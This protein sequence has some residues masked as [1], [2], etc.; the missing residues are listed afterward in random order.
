VSTLGN[1]TKSV[2]EKPIHSLTDLMIAKSPGVTILPGT[3]LGGAPSVR[4]RG[5]SSVSLSNAP[6]WYVD[7]VRF[8]ANTLSSG[9]D[10][11]FSLLSTLNPEE[12]EDIEIVKGPSAATLYGTNA[13]N[14]VVLITTK[15]GKAGSTRWTWS[16]EQR[17][18]VDRVPYQ[19]M[20]A[21]W[22]HDPANASRR[23][24]CQLSSMVT[25]AFSV[26]QGADCVSDSLTSYNYMTDKENTF[27]H[28]GK[29][30]LYGVNISGG[31]DAVRFFVSGDVDN[32]I[33][34]IEMPAYEIRRFD[35]LHVSVP[36]HWRHPS[37]QQRSAFRG[38]LSAALSPKFDLGF[39]AGFTKQDRPHSAGE[40]SDHRALLRRHAELRL[41]G[42]SRVAS[43][44]AVS[45]R[46][47]P[48]P[49]AHRFTTRCSSRRVTSC[50]SHSSRACSASR[51][52]RTRAGGR[53]A[54]CRTKAPSAWTWR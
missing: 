18:V 14:G 36:D 50:R 21:N 3:E 10:V 46:F 38:N 30:S 49:T 4:I 52:A 22:G 26:A 1:V 42:L 48:R 29:G 33:G 27:V 8:S 51:A 47:R 54:G 17:S 16:T 44:R 7:G 12:I 41:Q 35:S 43:R 25:P 31:T 39:N 40:R 32:E 23:I 45:T 28:N 13:A 11:N 24:R 9:T 37:A 15:K 20:Y 2:E 19:A 6:I 53:S 34:P 5:V